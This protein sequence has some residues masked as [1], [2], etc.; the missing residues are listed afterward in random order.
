MGL[1]G[2]GEV[3]EERRGLVTAQLDSLAVQFD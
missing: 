3:S 2:D 1:V